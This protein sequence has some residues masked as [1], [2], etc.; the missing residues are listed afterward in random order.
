MANYGV[1]YY[2][3]NMTQ[4]NKI[5]IDALSEFKDAT[6][7]SHPNFAINRGVRVAVA[8]GRVMKRGEPERIIGYNTCQ[9]TKYDNYELSSFSEEAKHAWRDEHWEEDLQKAYDAGHRMAEQ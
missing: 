5:A 3:Y 9:V 4:I 8:I 2:L 6:L 7:I 1:L